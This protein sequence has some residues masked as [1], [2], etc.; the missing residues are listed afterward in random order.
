MT[1]LFGRLR[2]SSALTRGLEYVGGEAP[3]DSGR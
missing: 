1:L 2:R 3:V